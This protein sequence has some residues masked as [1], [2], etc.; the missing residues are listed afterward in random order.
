DFP[1]ELAATATS[2]MLLR[3]GAA[4]DAELFLARLMAGLGNEIADLRS[5]RWD[6]V[7]ERFLSYAPHARG[8]RVVLATG[9]SGVTRGLDATGALRIG[10]GDQ[11]V[12]V[13][14]GESV[15]VVE[16]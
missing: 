13:H 1:S 11:E 6:R 5:S 15:A 14:A 12:L 9:A 2:L 3:H 8:A 7:A 4:V 10:T 16:E